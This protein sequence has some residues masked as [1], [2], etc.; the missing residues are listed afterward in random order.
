MRVSCRSASEESIHAGTEEKV[1]D[2]GAS[3]EEGRQHVEGEREAVGLDD[4]SKFPE[5]VRDPHW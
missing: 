2:V 1:G 3:S 4:V 5:E